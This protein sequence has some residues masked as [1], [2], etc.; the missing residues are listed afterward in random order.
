MTGPHRVWDGLQ[1]PFGGGG[2]LSSGFA[3]CS[4]AHVDRRLLSFQDCREPGSCWTHTG[5]AA[6]Q[7]LET[8]A[9]ELVAPSGWRAGTGSHGPDFPAEGRC[10][11]A[12]RR[13]QG[14][15]QCP[16]CLQHFEDE[17]GEELF[18]HVAECCQ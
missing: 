3:A 6:P 2:R 9:L 14:E 4:A 18:R 17:Q 5:S 13:G 1:V 16:H 12:T 7:Y 11:G 10:P 8:E 15:L